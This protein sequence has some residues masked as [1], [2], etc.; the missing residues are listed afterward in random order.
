[1]CLSSTR[2][3][4]LGVAPRGALLSRRPPRKHPHCGRAVERGAELRR[5]REVGRAPVVAHEAQ[6]GRRVR[7]GLEVEELVHLAQDR[8]AGDH[9]GD[10]KTATGPR[11]SPARRRSRHLS[12]P[13][14]ASRAAPRTGHTSCCDS[15]AG[16]CTCCSWRAS[17]HS[18]TSD[19]ATWRWAAQGPRTAPRSPGNS[20]C[21]PSR[22]GS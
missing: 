7:H 4:K 3:S 8:R 10:D 5:G 9:P 15:P 19:T 14:P 16:E 1:M 22:C 12:S 13:C 2:C 17:S 20:S 18:R 6:L 21:A 11:H